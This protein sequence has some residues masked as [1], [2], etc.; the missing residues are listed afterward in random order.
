MY[1]AIRDFVFNHAK[2]FLIGFGVLLI[3]LDHRSVFAKHR[4]PLSEKSGLKLNLDGILYVYDSVLDSTVFVLSAY[5][6]NKGEPT[7]A[8]DWT[9][10]YEIGGWKE[11]MKAFYL[12][13]DYIINIGDESITIENKHLIQTQILT[14]RLDT[15]EAKAGRLIF[16][17]PGK[18]LDQIKALQFKIR[19]QCSDYAD[20][21]TS[22][23]FVP[24][25]VPIVG[26][27]MYPGE[28]LSKIAKNSQAVIPSQPP[29]TADV[30]KRE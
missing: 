15:G 8:K 19:V 18:R 3:W 12:I 1:P 17:V 2:V 11:A 29:L 27:K 22:A 7:I 28:R 10:E 6:I 24:D 13:S 5:L 23:M 26:I 16:S 9:A 21:K 30:D 4:R 20:R 14:N 25:P